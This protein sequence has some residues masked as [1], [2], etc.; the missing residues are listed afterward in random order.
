MPEMRGRTHGKDYSETLGL[1]ERIFDGIL[2][3]TFK[4]FLKA[5]PEHPR[6]KVAPRSLD[7]FL[8]ENIGKFEKT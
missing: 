4:R 7:R 1:L 5:G 3:V 2:L 8:F 6:G